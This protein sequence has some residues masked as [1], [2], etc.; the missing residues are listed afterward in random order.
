MYISILSF[1]Y[2]H[3]NYVRERGIKVMPRVLSNW[4]K[5]AK[6]RLIELDMSITE[7]ARKVSLTREYTS[8]LVNGRVYSESAIKAISDVLNISDEI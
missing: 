8:A 4:C 7:L 1:L 3:V 2:R 6:I 5:K